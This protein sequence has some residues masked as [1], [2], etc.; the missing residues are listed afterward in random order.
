M[1]FKKKIQY[2]ILS[3]FLGHNYFLNLTIGQTPYKFDYKCELEFLKCED[4]ESA[5]RDCFS[6]HSTVEEQGILSPMDS[7]EISEFVYK[8]FEKLKTKEVKAYSTLDIFEYDQIYE[9]KYI[10]QLNFSPWRH[11]ASSEEQ[12]QRLK[13][14]EGDI[15]NYSSVNELRIIQEWYFNS[16]KN[17]IIVKDISATPVFYLYD[18]DG[19]FKGKK[20]YY[21][22]KMD[23]HS[24][25]NI[26]N[27]L[28]NDKNVIWA[29]AIQINL[30]VGYNKY[31]WS[32]PMYSKQLKSIYNAKLNQILHDKIT[33][34]QMKAYVIGSEKSYSI[35]EIDSL[36]TYS[37]TDYIKGNEGEITREQ[38]IYQL[39]YHHIGPLEVFYSFEIDSENLKISSHINKIIISYYTP[40]D[41]EGEKNILP[42]KF[43]IKF[44]SN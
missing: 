6:E 23:D 38:Y 11:H 4:E 9:D 40:D 19:S 44:N 36:L 29:N 25:P 3:F 37:I 21:Q 14:E 16:L 31:K 18:E 24:S 27:E 41:G 43:E 1:I 17:K 28:I 2:I 12:H 10:Q 32:N 13:N 42:I 8:H 7:T 26:N 39:N 35:K 20:P 30:P 34:G 5:E 15:L 22:I 33:S